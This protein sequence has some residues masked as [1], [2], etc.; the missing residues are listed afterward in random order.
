MATAKRA[1][2]DG[3][4]TTRKRDGAL[5]VRVR[6]DALPTGRRSRIVPRGTRDDGRAETPAQHRKRAE[7][8][9][10]ELRAE[11]A[12]PATLREAWTVQRYATERYVPSL[13]GRKPATVDSYV[14][15]LET[16]VYP[17]VGH[18]E[19]SALTVDHVDDH[20]R[21]L[22]DRGLSVTSRRHARGALA[23]VLKH[24]RAKRRIAHNVADDADPIR[25]QS[26]D[27]TKGVLEAGEVRA[28]LA[29]S[30]G[31]PWELP[32]ALLALLGLR[33]SEVLGLSWDDVD[34]DAGTLTVRRSLAALS[35]GRVSLGSPK[36]A[37][38]VRTLALAPALVALLRARRAEQAAQR[39]AAGPLWAADARDEDGQPVAL[40]FTDEAGQSLPPHRLGD[41]VE[42]IA[43]AAIGRHVHPHLLRHSVAS[44]M[45]AERHDIAAVAT[46]GHASPA[47]TTAVY[48]HSLRANRV[49]ATA[50]MSEAVGQW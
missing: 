10:A 6:D 32:V 26:R 42:R 13:E 28:F 41:A 47:T 9:L 35:G 19:L 45:L 43:D 8:V 18:V 36:T 30:K 39:L 17:I 12:R 15:H 7:A 4:I 20:D 27:R 25:A 48:S 14:R 49:R 3:S 22:R 37:G 23:R 11:V 31:T 40:V 24:A 46:L 1:N 5:I 34:I 33:R 38:S 50:A 21:Q 16:W 29:A 2:G 44:L